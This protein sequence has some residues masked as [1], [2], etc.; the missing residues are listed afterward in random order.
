MYCKS[1]TQKIDE[2]SKFCKYCGA[3][4]T[5]E[6][7]A[8]VDGI[9]LKNIFHGIYIT[10][11]SNSQYTKEEFDE[12]FDCFKNYENKVFSNNDFYKILVD[13]VFYS[14]FKASTVEK[15]LRVIHSYFDDY[16]KVLKYNKEQVD[17][18]KN[19]SNM[20]R[21]RNKIDACIKNAVKLEQIINK[22]GSVQNYINSFNP[23]LS[24]E[25]LLRLKNRLEKDFS[26]IGD[27]TSYHV[28]TDIGLN[29]LKPDRVILRIFYRLGLLDNETDLFG[30]VKVGRSF[31]LILNL[32]IRY[33]DI[34]FVSYGQLNLAKLECI[35]SEKNPKCYKC[36]ANVYCNYAN[37]VINRGF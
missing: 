27:T 31:S 12:D 26:F 24:D 30:A 22:Y 34:I 17:I 18:I 3:K 4:V 1:C 20:I 19:D 16:K 13:V 37:Q 14:G 15:Y 7:K 10:L 8:D 35:C 29:V 36:G 32:P 21:N 6:I 28:M 33:I 11:Q 2:D 23:N 25:C 5:N 9:K